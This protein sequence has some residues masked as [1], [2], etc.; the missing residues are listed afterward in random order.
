MFCCL[1]LKA[2]WAK[3]GEVGCALRE[4]QWEQ[5]SDSFLACFYK[6]ADPLPEGSPYEAG[7]RCTACPYGV[8]CFR[9]Q[10][11]DLSSLASKTCNRTPPKQTPSPAPNTTVTTTARTSDQTPI[12]TATSTRLSNSP[13][14][15]TTETSKA[16]KSG[17]TP[18]TT[19]S[20]TRLLAWGISSVAVLITICAAYIP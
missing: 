10:C 19:S 20:S 9:N 13:H 12:A 7:Y 2:V 3:T 16:G 15:K 1:I 11:T 5:N 18:I 4:C 17:Q 8:G 14:P 6:P